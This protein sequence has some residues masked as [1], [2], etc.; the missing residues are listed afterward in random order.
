MKYE[1]PEYAKKE[2][3]KE[4]EKLSGIDG[5]WT[6]LEFKRM[7]DSE[8]EILSIN[9]DKFCKEIANSYKIEQEKLDEFQKYVKSGDF[10][11]NIKDGNFNYYMI[12]LNKK[13][14]FFEKFKEITGI[15]GEKIFNYTIEIDIVQLSLDKNQY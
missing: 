12:Q 9:K 6:I 8:K 2:I 3:S 10:Q 13:D 4:L 1:I 11:F 14:E 15:D 5:I 7:K